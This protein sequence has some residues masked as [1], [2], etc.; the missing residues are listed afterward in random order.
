MV[1]GLGWAAWLGWVCGVVGS[2]DGVE[3]FATRPREEG[4]WDGETPSEGVE[5]VE[6]EARRERGDG[7]GDVVE[8]D[9]SDGPVVPFVSGVPR[10]GVEAFM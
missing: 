2:L 6:G 5:D 10:G 7:D 9:G 1:D 3:V 4:G 8:V